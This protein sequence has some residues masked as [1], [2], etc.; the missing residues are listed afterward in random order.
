MIYEMMLLCDVNN[1]FLFDEPSSY[2]DVRQRLRAAHAIRSLAAPHKYIIVV[3]HDLSVLDYLSDY[4]CLLYGTAGAYGVV[5]SPASVREALNHFLAG[6]IPNENLR[7]RATEINFK[8]QDT[9]LVD[10]NAD[11]KPGT[12]VATARK[13]TYHYPAMSK[14]MG[15]SGGAGSFKLNV[16]SGSFAASEIIVMLG[17]NGTGKTTFI[18]LLA[19]KLAPDDGVTPPKLVVSYKPQ[20]I[21][22]SFTVWFVDGL[23]I[24]VMSPLRLLC[25]YTYI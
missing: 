6:Y 15:G 16:E 18:K 21:A 24:A 23:S 1:S 2:L 22:T 17:Q 14:T 13:K 12:V 5:S 11:G 19:G 8:I 4:V 25:L 7:F 10:Y 9:P 20:T 3:E